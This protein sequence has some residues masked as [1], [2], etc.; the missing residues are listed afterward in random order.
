MTDD[1][2]AQIDALVAAALEKRLAGRGG[3][4]GDGSQ[5]PDSQIAP[6]VSAQHEE[7]RMRKILGPYTHGRR[8]RLV[9]VHDDGRRDRLTFDSEEA[10]RAELARLLPKCEAGPARRLTVAG[11]IDRYEVSQRKKNKPRTVDTTVGRLRRVLAPALHKPVGNVTGKEVRRWL[12]ALP[13]AYDT[14]R[15]ALVELR[16]FAAWLV[17][18]GKIRKPFTDGIT[19][20]GRR[21]RGK[22]QLTADEARRYLTAAL[23]RA[24]AEPGALAAALA[25]T[26]GVRVSEVTDRVVRDLDVN[27]S[28]LVVPHGKTENARRRL[29]V[30]AALRPLLLA[31][32]RGKAPQASLLGITRFAADYWARKLCALANVPVVSMHGLRGTNATLRN[33]VSQAPERIAAELG[34]GS[35]AVTAGH[36]VAPDSLAARGQKTAEAALGLGTAHQGDRSQRP[37]S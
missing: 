31:Q 18:D 16:T 20:E 21:R 15:V 36:Y 14:Q 33:E 30:P 17:A 1:L 25:V 8:H 9:V 10:A 29:Q 24:V 34:H 19:V 22:P 37:A 35:F 27:G 13:W 32:A 11:A 4:M 23:E 2:T 5:L 26:M 12:L 7:L 3:N 28:V 6:A